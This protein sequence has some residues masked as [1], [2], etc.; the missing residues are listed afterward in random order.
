[1]QDTEEFSLLE[2]VAMER[3]LKT[4]QAEEDLLFAAVIGKV[5]KLAVAL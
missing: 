1:V 2:A 5:W 3:L 4:M